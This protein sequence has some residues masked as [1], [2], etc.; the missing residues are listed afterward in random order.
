MKLSL[1]WLKEYVDL[2]ETPEEIGKLLTL[3]IAEVD[4]IHY[5]AKGLEHVVVGLVLEAKSHPDADKLHIGKFD[6]GEAEPRQIVFGGKAELK[7]GDRLPVALPGAVIGPITIEK[8]KLRGEVSEG[9]CCL[10]SELGIL[11]QAERVNFLDESAAPGTPI[12][13]AL[14]LN[15]V[16]F[17]IDN[18]TLTH[19]PDL[20]NHI[21]FA[22]ELSTLLQRPL[23]V[24]ALKKNIEPSNTLSY[25]LQ[26]ENTEACPRY[27]GA[28]LDSVEIKP[29]PDWM[30]RRL[31]AMGVSIINNVVDITN[32]VMYEYGQPLHAFDYAKL[33]NGTI[34][35][36]NAVA[37]EQL[38]TLDGKERTLDESMLVIADTTVPVAL[39]GIIGGKYSEIESTTTQIALESAQFNGTVIRQAAQKAAVRTDGS[40]RHE[41]GLGYT[42]SEEGFWRAVQLLE[43]YAGAR[44]ASTV[45]DTKPQSPEQIHVEVPR[46][47]MN[48]LIGVTIDPQQVRS[49]LE[50]L[51]CVVEE[52]ATDILTITVPLHRSDLRSAQDIIEEVA[53][54]YGYDTIPEAPLLGSL[55]PPH[56][57][58]DFMLGHSIIQQLVGWGAAEMY[59]YS[60]YSSDDAKRAGLSIDE[61][62]EML[63]PMNPHQ[64]LLRQTCI[65]N[66]L[67]NVNKNS[68]AGYKEFTLAEYGH[69]YFRDKEITVIE[70]VVVGNTT[71][72]FYKAK[73]LVEAVLHSGYVAYEF[74][75]MRYTVD[76]VVVAEVS[77]VPAEITKAFD[78][79]NAVTHFRIYL[80]PLSEFFPAQHSQRMIS[81]YPAIDLDISIQVPG[82][83]QWSDIE[84]LIKQ[85]AGDLLQDIQ[86]F[87]VFENN[88]GVRMWLQSSERTLEM[89]EAEALREKIIKNLTS[90]F[91]I[92]HRY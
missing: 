9:M 56:T 90:T 65:V 53:R 61:H 85:T 19:R 63:N 59:N 83:V 73:G 87:D 47:Y 72:T 41:K 42:F 88:L 55:Q 17:E 3:H 28:A 31:S 33:T 35:V 24:P 89:K 50:A 64:Q 5:Q 66:L 57:Q 43:E 30:Q 14:E 13:E 10:N 82:S 75:D 71:D 49:W 20:F 2:S 37:G 44:L 25:S 26:V 51:G 54:M 92:V 45:I 40:T 38:A 12:S 11:D 32:Y 48:R 58:P 39:A 23:R 52:N 62:I 34:V 1:N 29:S 18:K 16:I 36:R 80:Q 8:R 86:V 84:S 69:L 91:N 60:F 22:R 79:T 81:P 15:D 70:G 74:K 27:I 4:E 76:G 67:H 78:V 68:N 7:A 6:V 21:G 77:N 46:E